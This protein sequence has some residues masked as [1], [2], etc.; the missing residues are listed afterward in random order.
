[1][2]FSAHFRC[3]GGFLTSITCALCT[4]LCW[5][6][7][8]RCYYLCVD[9]TN[10]QNKCAHPIRLLMSSTPSTCSPS[11]TSPTSHSN[12]T[13]SH[14]PLQGCLLTNTRLPNK[15]PLAGLDLSRRARTSLSSSIHWTHLFFLL[16]E[17]NVFGNIQSRNIYVQ[18]LSCRPYP[19]K[20]ES[21]PAWRGRGSGARCLVRT[22][23]G[24]SLRRGS[25]LGTRSRGW[26]PL[27][28]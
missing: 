17:H 22:T 19:N 12:T 10:R 6:T 28:S 25:A 23:H 2:N 13:H 15:N 4:G 21:N 26:T 20:Y 3:T 5:R 27:H 14:T 1:M 9:K 11:L 7:A 24:A 8:V 18:V 16:K